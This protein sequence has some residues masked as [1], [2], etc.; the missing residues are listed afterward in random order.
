MK[1]AASGWRRH[2]EG[3]QLQAGRALLKPST[4]MIRRTNPA[5]PGK[6]YMSVAKSL[7]SNFFLTL[8]Y[9]FLERARYIA[10][11]LGLLR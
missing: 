7:I 4:R 8:V 1:G 11:L 2:R 10:G 5:A 9:T 3:V 6:V